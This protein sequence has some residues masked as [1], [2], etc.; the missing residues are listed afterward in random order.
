MQ[1]NV[2]RARWA[3][4]TLAYVLT[5]LRRHFNFNVWVI[6]T[7]DFRPDM[8]PADEHLN[9]FQFRK[10][11]D[12]DMQAAC[13]D[14]DLP[15]DSQFAEGAQVRGDIAYGAFDGARLV[16]YTWK[17][18]KP[19]PVD[20]GLSI[21]LI[22]PNINYGFKTFVHPAYRGQQLQDSVN[23]VG[24]KECFDKGFVKNLSYVDMGNLSS[25]K[26]QYKSPTRTAVGF[27]GYWK[28]G[29]RFFTWRSPGAR[30]YFQFDT[31][32]A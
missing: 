3:W 30:R 4:E 19:G 28:V 8:S 12:D 2:D 27:A 25:L 16:G 9:R 1:L 24:E 11:S 32:Q 17:T 18:T 14:P 13:S 7:R 15:I 20:Q 6:N 21:R 23:H 5:Y 22:V 10:L 26:S 29:S 31:D